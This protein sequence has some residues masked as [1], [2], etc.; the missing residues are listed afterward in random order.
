MNIIKNLFRWILE[1]KKEK[2]GYGK[3]ITMW[4]WKR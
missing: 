4:R 3:E 2:K 1:N